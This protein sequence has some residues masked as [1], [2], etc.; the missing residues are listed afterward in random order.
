MKVCFILINL[1]L[2]CILDTAK[3]GNIASEVSGPHAGHQL[4]LDEDLVQIEIETFRFV[5]H[6]IF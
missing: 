4:D 5:V 6:H 1:L 2:S 3:I